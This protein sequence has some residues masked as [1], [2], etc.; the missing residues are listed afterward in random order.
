MHSTSAT[1]VCLVH[2]P[3]LLE[4][5]CCLLMTRGY[6]YLFVQTSGTGLIGMMYFNMSNLPTS[7]KLAI[8]KKK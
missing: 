4:F 7:R 1:I 3:E 8:G 6:D 5:L 2:I